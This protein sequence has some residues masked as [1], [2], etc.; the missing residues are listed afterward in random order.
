MNTELS[1]KLRHLPNKPG[2]YMMKDERG[3]VIYVGKA[4]SLRSRV[5]SYFQKGQTH[6]T[7]VQVLVSKIQDIDWLVTDSELEAL[8]LECNFIK[9]FR[10]YYNVLM[11]DDKHYPYLCATTS[12]PFPRVIV[13]RRVKQDGNKYFGPYV[14][15]TAMR[16]SLRV[17]R[18]AFR[19]RSCNKKLTGT[20]QDRPCL[21]LH[22]GQCE[23]P[24]SG[25]INKEK[26]A[27][28]VKDACLFLEGHRESVV[29]RL[30]KE[31]LTA[32]ENLEFERAARIRDQIEIIRRPVERQKI[33]NTDQVDQDIISINTDEN[34][35]CVQLLMVRSGKLLGQDHFF[36]DGATDESPETSLSE[37]MKQYYRDA[38]YIPKE[39]LLSHIPVECE[40][41]GNWLSQK[42][43]HKVTVAVP[44]RG[45]KRKLVEM[46]AENAKMAAELERSLEMADETEAAE[47]LAEL[48]K[49]LQLSEPPMRIEAYDISNI[50]GKEAVGSMVVFRKGVP[51]KSEYRRFKIK[52]VN[53]PDDYGMMREVIKRRLARAAEDDPKFVELPAL[54]LV[55]GGRG[56]LNSALEA[57]NLAASCQPPAASNKLSVVSLAKRLEE[58][59][60]PDKKDPLLL[61][62]D[63]RALRLLQRIRDEAHRFALA[64][65]HKLREKTMR[66]SILDGV[67]GIGDKRR[68]ALIRKFGSVVGVRRASLG[69]LISVPGMTQATAQA[70]YDTLNP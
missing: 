63:S 53:Q 51:A 65:H 58:I 27:E 7:K 18:K 69:E 40:I 1:E 54:I 34:S 5:R 24:C 55:D 10:P 42:R 23:S 6:S 25:Q 13:V 45:K 52:V 44:K 50:Q 17:I 64:Y 16:G 30:E 37:F 59:Y 12:E 20:E 56:Q 68:K 31:M 33:I 47:D 48:Q 11:R 46:A 38:A 66:K 28:L 57:L 3:D 60:L 22:L 49:V 8:M 41:L 39:I 15:T 36:L 29:E 21:N 70:V 4:A 43:G 2:A 9:K 62:R 26:Y 14:D 19:I 35:T 32:S 67:P 61:P